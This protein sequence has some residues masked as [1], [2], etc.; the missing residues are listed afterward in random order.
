MNNFRSRIICEDSDL[1]I[2]R[3]KTQQGIDVTIPRVDSQ[4][5]IPKQ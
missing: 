2:E 3:V 4:Q 1:Q 5:S